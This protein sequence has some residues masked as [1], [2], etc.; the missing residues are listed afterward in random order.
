MAQN[1]EAGQALE[2]AAEPQPI[3][4]TQETSATRA[5]ELARLL[6]SRRGERHVVALQDFPDPDAI[7]CGMAYREIARRY[8]I[9][10]DLLYD[11]QISHAENRALVNLLEIPIQEYEPAMD[12]SV[13][14]AAVFVDNQG[15]TTH[16]TDL[17]KAAGVPT[18]AVVDHHEP[19]DVLDPIFSDVRPLGAAATM[20]A[21]YLAS[22]ALLTLEAG[23]EHHQR[24]AT[25]LMHGLHSETD[26]FVRARPPEYRA[27]AFLSRFIDADLLE[28]V[29]CVQKSRGTLRVIER[30]LHSRT[31]RNGFSI[32]GVGY[33]RW[34]DRD[35]I[36]VAADFLLTEENVHTSI[37]YGLLGEEDGREVVTGS[38]RTLSST[39]QVDQFL[40]DALGDDLRGRPYGGGRSRAGGFEIEL[41]FLKGDEDDPV[42]QNLKWSLYDRRVRRKLFREAGVD[43]LD[44]VCDPPDEE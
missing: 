20:L 22:D 43:D 31:V 2:F 16:L 32:A 34:A 11:G 15:S 36:P 10:A 6:E 35:A 14:S 30:A 26:G 41:G 18:L 12:L 40:R 5:A 23:N 25:A 29:L 1:G 13:Y 27:A 28:K 8:D 24:L 38:L 9:D 4:T 42:G 3:A 37:V 33:V 19:D 39:M 17:L 21:E 7:S 44:D